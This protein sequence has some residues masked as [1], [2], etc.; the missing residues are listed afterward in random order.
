M[1]GGDIVCNYI[2]LEIG[3]SIANLDKIKKIEGVKNIH[4]RGLVGWTAMVEADGRDPEEIVKEIQEKGI[5]LLNYR[6]LR[7][8]T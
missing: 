5:E 1:Q 7:G 4:S 8:K 6:I 3:N 2:Y